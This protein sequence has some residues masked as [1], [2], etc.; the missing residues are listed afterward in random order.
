MLRRRFEVLVLVLAAP[1]ALAPLHFPRAVTIA[2]IVPV[3]VVLVRGLS[4]VAEGRP[5]IFWAAVALPAGAWASPLFWEESWPLVARLVWSMALAFCVARTR[6]SSGWLLRAYLA[7]GAAV[8]LFGASFHDNELAGVLTLYFPL[9][10]ALSLSPFFDRRPVQRLQLLL[11]T[12]LFGLVVLGT[13][14]RG[15]ILSSA[16]ALALVLGFYG[17]RGRLVLAAG[18]VTA[19]L[20]A[21]LAGFG[22]VVDV[23]IFSGSVQGFSLALVTSGRLPIWRRAAA[24]V[25]D[26]PLTGLGPG[27]FGPAVDVLYPRAHPMGIEDAHDLWLQVAVDL[28]V[29]AALAFLLFL[30]LMARR[31]LGGLRSTPKRGFRFALL[32][33]LLGALAAHLFYNVGDCVAPGTPG[34][35]CWWLFCGVAL[36][37]TRDRGAPAGSRR[38]AGIAAVVLGVSSVS[39]LVPALRHNR[40][41][42]AAAGVLVGGDDGRAEAEAL[43]A[44]DPMCRARWLAGLL[45]QDPA[46]RR[47]QWAELIRCSP[48]YLDL[49]QAVA[50]DDRGLAELA[51]VVQGDRAQ[52]HFWLARVLARRP[53]DEDGAVTRYRRGLE[54]EPGD[55]RAWLEL[56]NLLSANRP[57]E[58]LE[59]YG[60]ACRRGDPGANAC[61]RAGAAAE[62]LGDVEAAIRWYRASRWGPSR[63]RADE[64][65]LDP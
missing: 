5:L 31:L 57:E 28:G 22:R 55:A 65:E 25:A 50:A 52:A 8:A 60:E 53:E 30:V 24:A 42:V 15:G 13:G 18:G 64:L 54:L 40:A 44:A 1:P 46:E 36:A 3:A 4:R 11:L 6:D 33:G 29:P 19:L 20:A 32:V 9:A 27:G 56:G 17:R 49:L 43:L 14:S 48:A 35:V 38:L 51:A 34:N 58:A 10:G 47:S 39:W 16:L 45:A 26:F 21:A 63:D 41:A 62:R 2:A 7:S 59:A 61:V 12:F 23:L 37:S